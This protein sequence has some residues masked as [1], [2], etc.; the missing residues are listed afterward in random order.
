MTTT[1]R[2]EQCGRTGTR[3]FRTL[4]DDEHNV[5]ITVCTA[6]TACRKRWP[7]QARDDV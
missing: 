7:K 5:R 6:K 1:H 4:T 3:G 2:C